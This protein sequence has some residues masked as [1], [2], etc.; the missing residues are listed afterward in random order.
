MIARKEKA[1]RNREN[2][3][4][5]KVGYGF[6]DVPF[7]SDAC[8]CGAKSTIHGHCKSCWDKITKDASEE[9][10]LLHAQRRSEHK[11][12]MKRIWG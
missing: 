8:S 1:D 11:R 4:N 7:G 3:I 6:F 9:L 2:Q 5:E 12:T 10:S